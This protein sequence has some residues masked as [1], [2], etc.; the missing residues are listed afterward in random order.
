[1]DEKDSRIKELE[2]EVTKLRTELENTKQ[3]LK[4]YTA[5][6]Y[7]KEYYEKNKE[8]QKLRVKNHRERTGYK[9]IPTPEK[10]KAANRKYY[11]KKKEREA[12]A[13]KKATE[14]VGNIEE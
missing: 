4:R 11:L 13:K 5:P 9:Y 1:M 8:A 12:E 10:K 7:K 3:H 14:N 2:A 6:G